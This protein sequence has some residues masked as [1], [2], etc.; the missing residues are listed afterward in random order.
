VN[1]RRLFGVSWQ[2]QT[3]YG[4]SYLPPPLLR[5]EGDLLG[6]T[7]AK[8]PPWPRFSLPLHD[9]KT[10]QGSGGCNQTGRRVLIL[11]QWHP[12]PLPAGAAGA[13]TPPG[14]GRST[15]GWSGCARL[16]LARL[17]WA[18]LMTGRIRTI[19]APGRMRIVSSSPA[20]PPSH[21]VTACMQLASDGLWHTTKRKTDVLSGQQSSTKCIQ[22]AYRRC[23]QIGFQPCSRW[24]NIRWAKRSS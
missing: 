6:W 23:H 15:V 9:G 4:N 22:D 16:R 17:P 2:R 21:P 8:S 11:L 5:Y 13:P 18:V 7:L 24:P 19:S 10:W 14:P 3:Q 20:L 1:L 12:L